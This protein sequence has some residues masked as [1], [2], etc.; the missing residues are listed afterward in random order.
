M[1]RVNTVYI[2]FTCFLFAFLP[3][4]MCQLKK[5]L[6]PFGFDTFSD[7]EGKMTSVETV[8]ILLTYFLL[9]S[10]HLE[11][12]QLKKKFFP[13]GV[14]TFSDGRGKWQELKLYPYFLHTSCCVPA[15]WKCVNS[16]RNSLFL[17]FI[18]FQIGGD[19]DKSWT[20]SILFTHLLF[21]F[22]PSGNVSTRKGILSFWS[23]YIFRW[24][25]KKTRVETVSILFTC[26][27]F[28]F[29]PSGNVSK[30]NSFLLELTHFQMGKGKWEELK[31]YPYFLHTSC[32]IPAIWKCVDS[33]RIIFPFGVDTFSDGRRK[34]Q[35][36][37]LYPYFLHTSCC[38]PAIW[39]CFNSKMNAFWSWH[40]F[41]WEEKTTRVET[42][43][44]LFTYFLFAFLSSGK[45][46]IP[47]WIP[48]GVDTF[49][50]G[51]GKMRKVETVS[52]L[53]T[54]FLFAFR[55]S[56]NVSTFYILPDAFL[57]SGN[58][59]TPKG[60]FSF[61]SWHIFRWEGGNGKSWNC[62]HTFY[63]LRVCVPAIWKCVNSK[64]NS[65]WSWHIFR[66]GR[67]NDKSWNCIHTVYILPVC[68]PAIWKCV[69]FLHTSWC[70]PAIWKCVDSKRIFFPF[71]VDTFSDGRGKWQELKLYPYFLHTSCLRSC[72]LEMF[73]NEF[74][75]ELTHFQM[76]GEKKR[77]ETVSILFTYFLFAF[78]PSG[79]VSTPK[80]IPFGVDTFS[81]GEGKMT[82]VETVS[83]LCT[84]FLFAFRPSGNVST[85][86]GI[87]SFWSSYI[88]RWGRKM[89]RVETIHNFYMSTNR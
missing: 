63:I 50:D 18:H 30:R 61:W 41:R 86:K 8:A 70:I 43:S 27:L 20:V 25:G 14:D 54:Y 51:E 67:E 6:F 16:K 55:P 77:V 57:S 11:M 45:V 7:G 83:I 58:V 49:S 32:C 39:K 84:Y 81:D 17:E 15:I 75:L 44:I 34:W 68:V 4:G 69:N 79:N 64:M 62:I 23:S 52:I 85:P 22:L 2:L 19:S 56:G 21:A 59:S 37:K 29:L 87:L 12:C 72:H 60:F 71:G 46:S 66:W 3:S 89:T 53:C 13:F 1:T 88:F 40:I 73:Q 47:K 28:A 80:W 9:R 78:L 48:F 82:R 42:V 31:L 74:L 10:C 76:G 26:F 24:E 35:E 38:V 33:K 5:D 65:F 36:L